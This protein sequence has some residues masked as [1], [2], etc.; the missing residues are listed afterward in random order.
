LLPVDLPTL[1]AY[2]THASSLPAEETRI[3]HA[4]QL[5]LL[6]YHGRGL[7]VPLFLHV[8]RQGSS[9]GN[10]VKGM[11]PPTTCNQRSNSLP[12]H[13][14][15]S[16]ICFFSSSVDTENTD[17]NDDDDTA[18]GRYYA[19]READAAVCHHPS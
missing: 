2:N 13:H 4:H 14:L 9:C 19:I 18:G 6:A 3:R 5:Q 10:G 12:L 16:L 15:P 7:P 11:D 1:P 8:Q 17:S